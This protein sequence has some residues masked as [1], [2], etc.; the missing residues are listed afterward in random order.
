[1]IANSFA[2]EISVSA[3][4]R[5]AYRALTTD[6]DK[7]WG[8]YA[9][10]AS[11]VGDEI[12]FRFAPKG[13]SWK[14]QFTELVP[15]RLIELECI[16]ANHVEVGL[17]ESVREEWLGTKLKWGIEPNHNGVSISFVHE[18]LTPS[19]ECYE[20]CKTGWEYFFVNSLRD[21]LNG[22]GGTPVKA[23]AMA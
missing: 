19:L 4:A 2:R 17:P 20:V 21:Y 8:P 9:G 23:N 5:S 6:F 13:T 12:T 7:W 18:G 16:E 1:M 14:M 11:E 3:N 10:D 22:K 15:D